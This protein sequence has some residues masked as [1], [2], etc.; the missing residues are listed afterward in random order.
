[1][2]P[3]KT[4]V[5]REQHTVE[6]IRDPDIVSSLFGKDV[7]NDLWI[8]NGQPEDVRQ[9]DDS[10]VGGRLVRTFGEVDTV[11]FDAFGRA[12]KRISRGAVGTAHGG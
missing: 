1:M 12:G 8:G 10:F 2:S 6:D 9:D 7:G 11:L 4:R 5:D 3:N